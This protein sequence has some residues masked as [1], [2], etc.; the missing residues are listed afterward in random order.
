MEI[1]NKILYD[2]TIFKMFTSIIFLKNNL[3][4][5]NICI[6]FLIRSNFLNLNAEIY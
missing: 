3:K 6:V 1:I 4:N 2:Y 5:N